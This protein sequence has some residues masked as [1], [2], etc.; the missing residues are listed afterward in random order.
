MDVFIAVAYGEI[1]YVGDSFDDANA[2][3]KEAA[4][5]FCVA[6]VER[7][8]LNSQQRDTPALYCDAFD[9]DEPVNKA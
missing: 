2:K 4:D 7:W 8:T 9:G 1:L 5:G 6:Y 3:A